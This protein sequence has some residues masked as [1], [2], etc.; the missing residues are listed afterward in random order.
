LP[1]EPRD[2]D[3]LDLEPVLMA[4]WR[5]MMVEGC[6]P[7]MSITEA[8][9]VLGISVHSVRRRIAAGLIPSYRDGRGRVRIVPRLSGPDDKAQ[10]RE[11]TDRLMGELRNTRKQ[12]KD[13]Q[14]QK[15][16]LEKEL[17]AKELQLAHS[18][19]D[20][21]AMWRL[22]AARSTTDAPVTRKRGA[23]RDD[24][25]KIQSQISAVRSLARRRK[26]P[27]ALVS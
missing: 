4:V 18:R 7:E 11:T 16:N 20:L 19:E 17:S 24:V 15:A 22:L 6:G 21:A 27:W 23:A 10:G 3:S 14:R 13:T 25:T 9:A 26:W 12:L 2:D 8:A 5:R 1:D